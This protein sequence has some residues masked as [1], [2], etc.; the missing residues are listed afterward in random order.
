LKGQENKGKKIAK[1]SALLYV[2]MLLVILI[3]LYTSRLVL[4]ELGFVD[5]GLYNLIAGLVSLFIFFGNSLSNA[6]QRFFSVEIGRNDENG[7]QK[8]FIVG[9]I[10][11]FL[12][13]IIVVLVL[14][15]AGLW[16]IYSKL[17]IP[18]D[19]FDTTLAVFHL[20]VI[21]VFLNIN[22][23][24]FRAIIIANENMRF[25][26]K[27]GVFEAILKLIIVLILAQITSFDKLLIYAILFLA[28]TVVINFIYGLYCF[29]N[30]NEVKFRFSFDKTVAQKM[31]SFIGWSSFVSLVEIGNL[32]GANV[33]LNIFFGPVINAAR[34]IAYQVSNTLQNFGQNIYVASRPQMIKSYALNDKKFFIQILNTSTKAIYFFIL[35]IAVPL[36]IELPQILNLWLVSVP[37]KTIEICRLLIIATLI[38]SIRNPLWAS[39]QAHGNLKKYSLYGGIV[40]L[41]FLPLAYISL[42]LYKVVELVFY[43]LI[44]IRLSYL[45]VIWIIL[46]GQIDFLETKLYLKTVLLPIAITTILV[47]LAP[48]FASLYFEGLLSLIFVTLFSIISSIVVIFLFG[49]LAAERKY[50]IEYLQLKLRW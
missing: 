11:F 49:L 21:V 35:T 12:L 44:I 2:R 40:M 1:N 30:Y 45:I 37:D 5:F 41:F 33:L 24:I 47:P 46:N 15:S 31:F 36:Y 7:A 29:T 8:V 20:S 10:L 32:Q 13:S 14:E 19:R 4:Q 23:F 28:V 9:L 27:I 50:V 34:G 43:I 18:K 48:L 25:Y 6:A 38:D 22:S 39:A 42:Y 3:T 16:F 17:N 26:A